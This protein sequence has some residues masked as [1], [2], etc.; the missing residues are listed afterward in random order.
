MHLRYFSLD[1]F[2]LFILT[3]S[4][5]LELKRFNIDDKLEGHIA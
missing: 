3:F 2:V 1:V 4:R 5:F